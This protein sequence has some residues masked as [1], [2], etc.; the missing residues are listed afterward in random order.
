MVL[1][2][3]GRATGLREIDLGGNAVSDLAPLEALDG[4]RRLD[5]AGNAVEDLWPLAGAAWTSPAIRSRT[6]PRSPA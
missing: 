4:L 5:L 3:I 2:G 1:S 6:S